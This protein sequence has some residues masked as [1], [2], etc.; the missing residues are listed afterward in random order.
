MNPNNPDS[1]QL[2]SLKREQ[3]ITLLIENTMGFVV[4]RHVKFKGYSMAVDCH[5]YYAADW[6]KLS[7]RIK[8]EQSDR[9]TSFKGQ[10]IAIGLG[11]QDVKGEQFVNTTCFDPNNFDQRLEHLAS[12]VYTQ[13]LESIATSF[14]S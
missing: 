8:R 6:L 2:D 3:K 1:T 14:A 12:V 11:W 13:G 4:V 7:Y 10:K 9:I 5:N